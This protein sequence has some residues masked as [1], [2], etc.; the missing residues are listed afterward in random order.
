MKDKPRFKFI[1][2]LRGWALLVMIEVHVFNSMLIPTLKTE[3]WFFV[4]NF[5]NGLVAPS[6]LFVSGYA[7]IISSKRKIDELRTFGKAFRKKIGRIL[8]ILAAGYSLHFP[9]RSV[10]VLQHR[11]T[12]NEWMMFYNVDILQCIAIGLLILFIARLLI[13]ND[14]FYDYFIFILALIIIFI[15]PVIWRTDFSNYMPPFFAAYFNPKSGSLFPLFPWLG[16]MFLGATAC[17]FFL[18]F[19]EG[20]RERKYIYYLILLGIFFLLAGYFFPLEFIAPGIRYISPNPLFVFLRLGYVL[21]LLVGCWYYTEFRKPDRSFVLD[22]SRE[23]LFVYWLHLVL[24]YGMFWGGK[25]LYTSVDH[26]YG[27]IECMLMTVS[28][29]IVMILA[30]KVWGNIKKRSK[31]FSRA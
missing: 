28:I 15:S 19:R 17:K 8:L 22:I 14:K 30:A 1:D 2:Y 5:I 11:I 18:E 7:F 3:N 13:K 29:S 4:L 31:I 21:L 10:F 24:I 16:F 12:E 26:S 6:F 27:V 23:S 9:F 25:S 20:E